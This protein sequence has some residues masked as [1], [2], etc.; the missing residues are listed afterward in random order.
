[1]V[2]NMVMENLGGLMVGNIKGFRKNGNS[3]GGFL[4]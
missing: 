4:K 3:M 2:K 1:M